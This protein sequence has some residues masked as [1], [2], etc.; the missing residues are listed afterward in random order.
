MRGNQPERSVTDT[1]NLRKK[2]LFIFGIT[3]TGLVIFLVVISDRILLENYLH[4]EKQDMEAHIQRVLDSVGNEQ[5]QMVSTANDWAGWDDTYHFVKDRNQDFIEQ[6]INKVVMVNL[7]LNLLSYIQV[8]GENLY[9][10][11]LDPMEGLNAPVPGDLLRRLTAPAF[12]QKHLDEDLRLTGLWPTSNGPVIIASRPVLT[13]D[14][15]G[16]IYGVQVMGR[17]LNDNEI[18]RLTDLLQTPFEM[19]QVDGDLSTDFQEA[20]TF[21]NDDAPIFTKPLNAS[22][23]AAYAVLNDIDGKP[24]VIVKIVRP[25]SIYNQGLAGIRFSILA[26]LAVG[27]IAGILTL[28]F[29]NS[30]ILAP[31]TSLSRE[32]QDIGLSNDLSWRVNPSG[33]EEIKQLANSL[34]SM[35]NRLQESDFQLRESQNQLENKVEERTKELSDA[36]IALKQEMEERSQVEQQLRQAQKMEAIGQLAG[37]IAHDFNNV[38]TIILGHAY[39]LDSKI[40]DERL[41]QSL[42]QIIKGGDR[43]A[44]LVSQ[45]LSYSRR[46]VLKPERLNLNGLIAQVNDW[47]HRLIGEDIQIENKMNADAWVCVDAVH[48]E[49]VVIN[50]SLNA[51]DAM[52]SGGVLT[53]ET[54]LDDVSAPINID[55]ET[56]PVGQY[57]VLKITDTGTGMDEETLSHIFEPFFTTKDVGKG[58][59]L[60]LS[61]VY[62]IIKQSDGFIWAESQPGRGSTFYI[63]LPR[64]EEQIIPS[65]ADDEKPSSKEMTG[66]DLSTVISTVLLVEDEPQIRQLLN[67]ALT[68][69][70][71]NVLQATDGSHALDIC[72]QYEGHIDLLVT[73]VVMPKMNGPALA[74]AIEVDYPSIKVIYMSGY[75]DDILETYGISSS[76]THLLTKPFD[77]S[78]LLE[79]INE[80]IQ[81]S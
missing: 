79:K 33:P 67:D 63:Y 75:T 59:G 43:A 62:G 81:Y 28:V 47:L 64:V 4:L 29:L 51:R 57:A 9:S 42:Q 35:L 77:A 19:Q 11:W 25:R 46:Q 66:P 65:P 24:A 26:L 5:K 50:I 7:Q 68:A 36:N 20:F 15:E 48:F 32:V 45:I 10:Y 40:K 55:F 72:K 13:S 23:I 38:L 6:N 37:G 49:Q 73:D 69:A 22:S 18:A 61:M 54:C 53:I 31:L 52:T 44:S 39:L 56:I 74:K 60:G 34:N 2:V 3:L 21:I 12:I 16:P 58:S 80:I 17:Y 30:N 78:D 27:G 1:M 41:N 14:G 71:F 76:N 8:S 70:G